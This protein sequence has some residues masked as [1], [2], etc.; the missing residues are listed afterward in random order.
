MRHFSRSVVLFAGLVLSSQ[1]DAVGQLPAAIPVTRT[2]LIDGNRH[3]FGEVSWVGSNADQVVV[4][5]LRENHLGVY[6]RSGDSL[7]T[8]GRKGSGPG[9]FLNLGPL[10]WSGDRFLVSDRTTRRITSFGTDWKLADTERWPEVQLPSHLARNFPGSPRILNIQAYTGPHG[11]LAI[12]LVMPPAA[13]DGRPRAAPRALLVRLSPTGQVEGLIAEIP[14]AS[15]WGAARSGSGP[16]FCPTFQHATSRY[17]HGYVVT[18]PVRDWPSRPMAQV[19]RIDATG[20]TLFTVEMAVPVVPVPRVVRDS[21]ARQPMPPGVLTRPT[22]ASEYPPVRSVHYG[23]DG[24]IWI[25]VSSHDPSRALYYVVS[26]EGRL[27]GRVETA[28]GFRMHQA[29]ERELLGV[30]R[31]G[32]DIPSVVSYRFR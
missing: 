6:N 22:T 15:C 11:L 2:V 26:P 5:F 18:G 7:A 28:N 19:V 4:A 25:G 9:E 24:R 8:I 30:E 21:L 1:G 12:V 17:G 10:G 32:D 23:N 20:D 31:D 16:R 27:L 3:E 14:G 13:T 29:D